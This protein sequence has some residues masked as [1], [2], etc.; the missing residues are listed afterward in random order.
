M[1]RKLLFSSLLTGVSLHD[2]T[3]KYYDYGLRK[4]CPIWLKA[5][6]V[7]MHR[8]E[9][10]VNETRHLSGGGGDDRIPGMMRKGWGR[11]S[12]GRGD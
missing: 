4:A 12:K 7:R 9:G 5:S 10:E 8:E 1:R 3:W 6:V 11:R 2:R